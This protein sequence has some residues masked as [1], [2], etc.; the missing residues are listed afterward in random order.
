MTGYVR[1]A[2]DSVVSLECFED[3][4]AECPDTPPND[5]DTLVTVSGPLD[6]YYCEHGCDHGVTNA[7]M[8]EVEA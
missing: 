5:S 3:R 1:F 6:G 4:C 8:M 7:L 2:D